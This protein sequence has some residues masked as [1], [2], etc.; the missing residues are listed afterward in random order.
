MTS[1]YTFIRKIGLITL[2][3]LSLKLLS[4]A[5]SMITEK[6]KIME[7]A[8]KPIFQRV[9]DK[10][11]QEAA[12]FLDTLPRVQTLSTRIALSKWSERV[13]K[14]KDDIELD[15]GTERHYNFIF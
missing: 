10:F 4:N 8:D 13:K 9:E 5:V 3:S 11:F 12:S 15:P 14:D 7:P 2:S 1:N 6:H